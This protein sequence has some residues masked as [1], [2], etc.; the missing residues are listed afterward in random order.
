VHYRT[1]PDLA[2]EVER[3][4]TQISRQMGSGLE[5]QPGQM[6]MELRPAGAS[7]GAAVGEFMQESPFRG[8]FAVM[9][10][11]DLTDE[12]A[13]RWVNSAGGLSIAVNASHPTAAM[14]RLASV[15]DVHAWLHQCLATPR[16]VRL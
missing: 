12:S 11:D 7:K 10:G 1:A 15:Q 6:V 4:I 3:V 14:A 8:R 13:F 5:V 9:I 16:A 2:A